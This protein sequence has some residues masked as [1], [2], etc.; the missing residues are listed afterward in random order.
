M[1]S[2]CQRCTR[3]NRECIYTTHSKT[4][5]RKR[6]DT[7]VKEL[8]E[9]VRGLSLLLEHRNSSSTHSSAERDVVESLERDGDDGDQSSDDFGS[10]TA[11][12]FSPFAKPLANIPSQKPTKDSDSTSQPYRH[13][14]G[15]SLGQ[16]SAVSELPP[17]TPDV[18]DRGILN[19]DKAEEL[20]KRYVNELSPLYV[21]HR[22]FCV[23]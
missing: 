9:K 10:A 3:A 14:R 21:P 6:T 20:Y 11:E 2:K 1:S 7:R 22:F 18:V 4:R 23:I 15:A 16:I 13:S 5:R 19:M 12:G 17:Y 8:E